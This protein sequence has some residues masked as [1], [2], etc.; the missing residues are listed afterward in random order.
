[1]EETQF[2][3]GDSDDELWDAEGILDERGESRTGEYLINWRGVDPRTGRPWDPTWERKNGCSDDLIR[4]WKARKARNPD[5]VGVEGKKW[6]DKQKE[7]E[8][9]AKKAKRKSNEAS[10]DKRKRRSSLSSEEPRKKSKQTPEIITPGK[11]WS[12]GAL[13]P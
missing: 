13:T 6:E 2:E 8:K 1:M 3:E 4:S 7:K 9:K 10:K 12:F 11:A 5:I